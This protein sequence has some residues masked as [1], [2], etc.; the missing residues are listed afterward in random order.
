MI[1]PLTLLSDPSSPGL[2]NILREDGQAYAAYERL[3]AAGVGLTGDQAGGGTVKGYEAVYGSSNG[4]TNGYGNSASY[5]SAIGNVGEGGGSSGGDR[6]VREMT[7]SGVAA[8]ARMKGATAQDKDKDLNQGAVELEKFDVPL[9]EKRVGYFSS[10]ELLPPDEQ[11][12]SLEMMN[13]SP[14]LQRRALEGRLAVLLVCLNHIHCSTYTVTYTFVFVLFFLCLFSS[15]HLCHLSTLSSP[16]SHVSSVLAIA[17]FCSHYL[18]LLFSLSLSS[19]FTISHTS[20]IE[21]EARVRLIH[22]QLLATDAA[23][24][25]AAAVTAETATVTVGG[26]QSS[27][28]PLS[29]LDE[30]DKN[31]FFGTSSTRHD[32][33]ERK[34]E[35]NEERKVEINLHNNP[36]ERVAEE[37][38]VPQ[39]GFVPAGNVHEGIDS[40]E[41]ND[42]NSS[43]H[44]APPITWSQHIKSWPFSLR[45]SILVFMFVVGYSLIAAW[46][47]HVPL[48]VGRLVLA[49]VGFKGNPPRLSPY[50][51]PHLSPYLAPYLSH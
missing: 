16:C 39:E 12:A 4:D 8:L 32:N 23:A 25:A 3:K 2:M 15:R 6:G 49:S 30:N 26:L 21:L 41:E 46:A 28:L 35:V 1:S 27:S 42:L 31:T 11:T 20:G 43:L 37:E 45:L 18:S 17:L 36:H 9:K 7:A 14:E 47:M 34:V 24:A 44:D 10:P 48:A 13:M 40:L 33:E 38:V 29:P 51:S 19:V 22:Q 5:G 50:L